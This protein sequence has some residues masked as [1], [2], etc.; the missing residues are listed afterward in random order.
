MVKPLPVEQKDMGSVPIIHPKEY[1]GLKS[2]VSA[3]GL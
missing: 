3:S 2:I 1:G